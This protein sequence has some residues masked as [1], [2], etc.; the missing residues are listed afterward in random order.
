MW[1]ALHF[2]TPKN[3]ATA[4]QT[5]RSLIIYKIKVNKSYHQFAPS[6]F[7]ICQPEYVVKLKLILHERKLKAYPSRQPSFLTNNLMSIWIGVFSSML[8]TFSHIHVGLW[9]RQ[10]IY[11]RENKTHFDKN[12]ILK[13]SNYFIMPCSRINKLQRCTPWRWLNPTEYKNKQCNS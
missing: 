11:E 12:K 3:T 8:W 6:W 13:K 7:S 1:P 9:L 10:S 5:S 4:T 2:S